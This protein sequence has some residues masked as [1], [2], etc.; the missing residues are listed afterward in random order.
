MNLTTELII[1]DFDKIT[2]A[3]HCETARGQSVPFC[4]IVLLQLSTLCIHDFFGTHCCKCPGDPL[5][6]GF[7]PFRL[8]NAE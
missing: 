6:F 7:K 2:K 8:I 4:Q 1:F 3:G 5:R